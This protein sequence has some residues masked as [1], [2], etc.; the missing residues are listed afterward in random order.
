MKEDRAARA[1]AVAEELHQRY[2]AGCVGKV[3]PV[4][5]EQPCEGRYHGH[6]PNYMTV[7]VSREDLHNRVV[8]TRITGVAGELLTGELLPEAEN[9]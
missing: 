4:L 3:Y 5:Y 7:A 8:P 1:A 9:R 6:A 2:L